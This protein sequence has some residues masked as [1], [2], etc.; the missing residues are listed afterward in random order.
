MLHIATM[1]WDVDEHSYDFSRCY[2]E[3]W[4]ERLFQAFRR[5]LSLPFV[6]VCFTDRRRL[7]SEGIYQ[8]Q[9]QLPREAGY[10][11]FIEPFRL[12]VP[13]ILVGLDTIV[14]GNIDQLAQWCM[15]GNKVALP[16]D[17]Y[18]PARSINGVALI[19][20]GHS[21]IYHRYCE[22]LAISKTLRPT[23]M[24]FLRIQDTCFIDD[25]F[26]GDVI[27][28]KAHKV[29]TEGPKDAKIIYFHGRPKMHELPDDQLIKEHWI[30]G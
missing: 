26:P 21:G 8:E 15:T 18:Q 12:G 3:I 10:G 13:M 28:F 5:H 19:P 22:L 1:L 11:R 2:S 16:R 29:R 24:E 23:D 9:I 25:M 6:A 14:L 20:A 30:G 7:F 17:P 4:V 27:S